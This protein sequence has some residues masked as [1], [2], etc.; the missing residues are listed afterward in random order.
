[1]I[2]NSLLFPS[3]YMLLFPGCVVGLLSNLRTLLILL[4]S[5]LTRAKL[6]DPQTHWRSEGKICWDIQRRSRTRSLKHTLSLTRP[7]S[8]LL[9][10]R[11]LTSSL[12]IW[13]AVLL[14]QSTSPPPTASINPLHPSHINPG[15][16]WNPCLPKPSTPYPQTSWPLSPPLLLFGHWAGPI[17]SSPGPSE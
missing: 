14:S 16:H 9:L 17:S 15:G 2:A 11:Q 13:V 12:L 1:M 4:R 6:R 5:A 8:L 7:C 10:T 3:F